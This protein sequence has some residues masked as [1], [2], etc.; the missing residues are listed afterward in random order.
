MTKFKVGQEYIVLGRKVTIFKVT[1]DGV[2]YGK[3]AKRI[4]MTCKA[5]MWNENASL[6][7]DDPYCEYHERKI[8]DEQKD[9]CAFHTERTIKSEKDWG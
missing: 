2:Q 5:C 7:T 4:K 8:W 6:I 3:I 1:K 9:H